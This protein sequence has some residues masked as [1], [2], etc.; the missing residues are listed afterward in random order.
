MGFRDI[1]G[2]V[3][4]GLASLVGA[5]SLVDPMGGLRA[6]LSSKINDLNMMVAQKSLAVAEA[7]NQSI[8]DLYS[9]MG[10]KSKEL[11]VTFDY[12]NE[13]IW[14]TLKQDNIFIGVLGASVL[15]IVFFM[16]IQKS[17]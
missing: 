13:L 2:G 17:N 1:M 4:H 16:L 7:E 6:E 5:G 11:Q 14:D 15:I 3:G 8:K 12:N 10:T 9:L